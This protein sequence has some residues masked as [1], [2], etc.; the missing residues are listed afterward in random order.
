M[1]S[2]AGTVIRTV[3]MAGTV[4]SARLVIRARTVTVIA[5][6]RLRARRVM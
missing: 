2:I 3:I 1:G 6:M 4:I 5:R